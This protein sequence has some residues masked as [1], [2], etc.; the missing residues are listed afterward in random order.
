MKLYQT[1]KGTWAGSEK[2][3]TAAMKAEGSDPKAAKRKQVDVPVSKK[4]LME[5]LTFHNVNVVS[6]PTS[7]P[8]SSEVAGGGSP[9]PLPPPAGGTPSTTMSLSEQFDA[10]PIKVKIELAVRAL[11][12]CDTLV[13]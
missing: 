1:P 11:D 10:A 4:E 9:T 5:F 7:T 3:W 6:P 12:A 8:A 2:D 13:K